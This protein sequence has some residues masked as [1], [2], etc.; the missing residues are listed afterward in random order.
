MSLFGKD[1]DEVFAYQTPKIVV[2]K[3]RTLGIMRLCL[4]FFIFMYIFIF[5]MLFQGKH[6]D[7]ADVD[8]VFRLQL[9][10]PT[11]NMCSPDKIGCKANYTR[12]SKLPYCKE[13]S[14]PYADNGSSLEKLSC[15][16]W[17]AIEVSKVVEDGMLLPTRVRRFQ[18]KRD[19]IPS[20][21]NDWSCDGAPYINLDAQ[22]NPQTAVG[23]EAKPKYD[24]YVADVESFTMLIDH[25]FKRYG[26]MGAD[27]MSMQGS[28][29]EC[30]K[31]SSDC[32]MK[33]IPCVHKYC[34][35]E[36]K[37]SLLQTNSLRSSESRVAFYNHGQ[38]AAQG[39]SHVAAPQ[40]HDEELAL[41]RLM[42]SENGGRSGDN[43]E[44]ADKEVTVVSIKKGDV[45]HLGHMLKLAHVDLDTIGSTEG[46]DTLD[47]IRERGV[48]VVVHILYDNW[49]KSWAGL[50][51]NP[52]HTPKPF[53]TY[54][55]STRPSFDYKVTN[56]FGDPGDANRIVR[57]YNGI[58]VVIEQSGKI[59]VWSTTSFLV[60]FTSALGLMAVAVTI[61]D[62]MM[63]Y[64]M[65]FKEEYKKRKFFQSKDFNPDEAGEKDKSGEPLTGEEAGEW[66]LEALEAQ[67]AKGIAEVFPKL[68]AATAKGK[69]K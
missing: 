2:L 18:Q 29:V 32:K 17:D 30:P 51:V 22:G 1:L 41:A 43:T 23:E 35:E 61:T 62:M 4:T 31:G 39:A 42:V 56:V 57:V 34:P 58:R 63:M 67:D 55:V 50:V 9:Q 27:D 14:L 44:S 49:P 5:T 11:M 24:A 53:Y 26:G 40:S 28:I 36:D 33:K 6:L 52:W 47:G 60:T 16:L 3:D 10:Y 8:G 19:C 7:V 38:P 48:V 20:A 68:V 66:F 37:P 69:K 25:A 64:A 59:A 12:F 21:G 13:S 15:Q 46:L 65:P 54:K 45:F